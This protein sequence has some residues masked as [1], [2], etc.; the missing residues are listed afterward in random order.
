MTPE[1]WHVVKRVFESA[2]DRS[3]NERTAYL[4][5]VCAGD[6]SLRAE[7]D[8]LLVSDGHAGRFIEEP[9][10]QIAPDLL[11]QSP[12]AAT[13]GSRIGRYRIVSALGSGGMGEVFLAEDETLGRRVAL[14]VL[15]SQ[16]MEDGESEARFVREAHLASTLD[17]P[18]ICTVYEAGIDNGRRFISMQYVEGA[19]LQRVI[20]GRP[21][22]SAQVLAIGLQI[23]DALIA[24]HAH[25]IVHRDIKP[26]NV[27]V[28][29]R[30]HVKVLDFGV[31]KRV[32]GGEHVGRGSALTRSGAMVGTPSYISPE[33]ARGADVDHRSDIFSFGI[34]LYEMATGQLPFA[35]PSAVE[36]MHAIINAR[37][38][39]A[40]LLN[41][42][43][44][45]AI[46]AVIDRALQ[47]D[48]ASRYQSVEEMM[49]A[50]RETAARSHGAPVT[51]AS[52]DLEATRLR[53]PAATSARH[54]P[55]RIKHPARIALITVAA[56]L[57][58]VIAA[59]VPGL[60]TPSRELG[61]MAVLP[62]SNTGVEIEYLSDGLAES[63]TSQLSRLSRLRVMARSTVFSYKG[64]TV[65]PRAVGKELGVDA[66]LTG[67]VVLQNDTI[68]VRLEL[69]D[70]EDGARLWGEQYTRP[71]SQLF[72]LPGEL[73]LD[74][75][76]RLGVLVNPEERNALTKTHTRDSETYQLYVKGLY[77]S[78]K[79]TLEEARRA[80]AY[81]EQA[82]D[83]D[84]T[85][86][87][88]Y[89]GL[90][91]TYLVFRGYGL[92]SPQESLPKARAAAERALQLDPSV[93][94]AH[95]ALGWIVGNAMDWSG[96]EAAFSRAI[97]LNPNYATA[98][99]RY[100]MYLAEM[101]RLDD[102]LAGIRRAQE[103]DPLSLIINSELGRVL[104]LMRRYDDAIVQYR[105][106]LE[107]DRNFAVAHL[108]LGRAYQE[109]QMYPEALA[110]FEQGRAL[111]GPIPVLQI[112]SGYARSGRRSEAQKL[113][114]ELETQSK[115]TFVPPGPLA[116]LH[117]SLGHKE[118][119]LSLIE[120][121]Y[122]GGPWFL[123][124]HPDW[125][126]LR[127]EPRFQSVLKRVGLAP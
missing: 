13:A 100:A 83:R 56:A 88:A 19:T 97:T 38:V 125:D 105:K 12:A 34:V 1:R 82:I 95:A 126:T 85:Y 103:L 116:A 23:A 64:R 33:Q 42:E 45:A 120:R 11:V 4:D 70:V 52:S 49:A 68:V 114:A 36:A 15:A 123:M 115:S 44:P 122:A 24:A 14:K 119:A 28:T 63:L 61:S 86:A 96:A 7:V 79:R 9:V 10:S 99:H 117:A 84:P 80:I 62:F 118:Q 21:L 72:A 98:H 92:M 30:G 71:I 40:S 3:S 111:G 74:V 121:S 67:D 27:M 43:L 29:P 90:A 65:D 77:F 32:A 107:M 5:A 2:L 91:E 41:S 104:F 55:L 93:P 18:N 60:V 50:L 109:K 124:T 35:G 127:D 112:A 22:P 106:T 113:L 37:Q 76:S 110:E 8:A 66:V 26:G 59:R 73:A 58:G 39:S 94:E 54:R 17:H 87:L 16:R 81:F 78:N 25:G 101:G 108:F 102:A 20:D 51:A 53:L 57:L 31:A 69:V 47:K 46:A 48:P 6:H 75:S 89:A